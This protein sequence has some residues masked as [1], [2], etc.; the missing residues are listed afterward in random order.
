MADLQLL[1]PALSGDRTAHGSL[2]EIA[3]FAWLPFLAADLGGIFGGYRLAVPDEIFARS[4]RLVACLRR[5]AGGVL[6][7]GPGCIG[8]SSL[9]YTAIAL[10]CVGGFA[11]QTISTLVNTLSA[12]IFDSRDVGTVNGFAGM[13]AS[14]GGLGF[15]LLVGAFANMIGYGPLFALLGVF[16]IVGAILLISLLRGG[17]YGD[18]P[19]AEPREAEILLAA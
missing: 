15:S 4:A 17:N 7:I 1:D 6:M 10:F 5:R 14:I 12:D 19:R 16:D 8:S 9:P 2:E 13:A 3:I 11:H 18:P